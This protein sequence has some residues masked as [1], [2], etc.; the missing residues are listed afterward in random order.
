MR[1][2]AQRQAEQDAAG[3]P[4]VP[5][6][7]PLP[8]GAPA[9]PPPNVPAV[10][11][12]ADARGAVPA[13]PPA[14]VVPPG[15][16]APAGAV[17]PAA[18]DARTIAQAP[19][20]VNAQDRTIIMDFQDVELPVLVKFISE[21]TGRNFIVDEKVRGKVTIISPGKITVDEAYLVFQSVLQVKGF[22]TVQA[23]QVIK[24]VQTAE[25]KSSTL[26]TFLPP[27]QGQAGPRATDEYI[28]RL[29]PLKFVDANS[30]VSI[31]QPLVSPDGLLAAYTKTNTLI[32][33]DTAAQTER[34]A[35]IMSQLDV[36]GF[37]QKVEVVRLRYAFAGDL[38][39]LLQEVL[40]E[41]EDS[42]GGGAAVN[43]RPA[44]APD[45]RLRRGAGAAARQPA[46]AGGSATIS[47]GVT[48]ERSFRIIPDERIN[49]LIIMAGPMEMRRIQDLIARLDVPIPLGTGR[50]HVYYLKYAN[51][52]ELA[53][54]LSGLV[55]G[56]GGGGLS[57]GGLGGGGLGS[58][59]GGG[60][61]FGGTR[62]GFGS[63]G[64]GSSS[65]FG[66][67]GSSGGFGS[68]SFG[69]SGIGGGFGSSSSG[70]GGFGRGNLG[71]SANRRFGTGGSSFGGGGFGSRGGGGGG[72]GNLPGQSEFEGQVGISADP[73]T[74][75]LIVIASPQDYETIKEVIEKLDVRRRQVYVEAIIAEVSLDKTRELGIELQGAVDLAGKGAGFGRT[76]LGGDL[77][78]AATGISGIQSLSGLAL[79]A[80]SAQ[81][82]TIGGITIPAQQA[83]L[84]ALERSNDAEILS[85]PTL[86]TMDNT[87]AEIVAGQN[88]PFIASRS[89]NEVNLANTF[90]TIER[91]DVGIT[92]RLVPQISEGGSVR[93]D[94][95]QE[96]SAVISTDPQ[97]GPTTTVRSATTTIVVKDGH[98]GV[99]GGVLSDNA[100][101]SEV[102]IPYLSD[103]PVIGNLF[104]FSS[105][106]KAKTN[107]LV[108]LTPH[109]VRNEPEQT[110]LSLR[111]RERLIQ[112]PYED[113]G[114]RPPDWDELYNPSWEAG[115]EPE[116]GTERPSLDPPPAEATPSAE[117]PQ[118]G[119][120]TEPL[121]RGEAA[122]QAYAEAVPL[123]EAHPL[124]EPG[125]GDV[126]D[127]DASSAAATGP[128]E[129]VVLAT[130]W[131]EGTPP[132][133]LF[134]SN[135][136]VALRVA[137]GSTLS[138]M[139]QP[140]A[141]Y[142]F[143][144]EN[145]DAYF[146]CLEVFSSREEAFT[147]YPDG[148]RVSQY[149][150]SFLHWREPTDA[151]AQRPTN[152]SPAS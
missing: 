25:A 101:R 120:L 76:N 67:G 77:N 22:T 55:G 45:A 48:P 80:T 16:A 92:L 10:A 56:G 131:S 95:F 19:A 12:G 125:P 69:Q 123:V 89:T 35:K 70:Q 82:I 102:R 146:Q 72:Q 97:L 59:F 13:P 150:V 119:S 8:P 127:M 91:Q 145:F 32:I 106:G 28:T 109:I 144:S 84:R 108:F 98:T 66:G 65:R 21:I 142:R 46:A 96:V 121:A 152:W 140:G 137:S 110:R 113:R 18:T 4:G 6:G 71:S 61:G 58:S 90:A 64:S 57:G 9:P 81:S 111:E 52:L 74:N 17:A 105:V 5:Q 133:S 23:G 136:L 139:F 103:I 114:K 138:G 54:V 132:T 78:N 126:Y 14:G 73:A 1:A 37:E 36:E 30:M 39:A 11:P 130:V 147:I 40:Q 2:R 62:G 128:S 60:G 44:N 26:K 116:P 41:P 38:A 88:V 143:D 3:Q 85:A 86:M 124:P 100:T 118:Q 141:G 99:I 148:M 51:A 79:G 34:L 24:I 135:G 115:L 104:E 83:L 94:I 129:Y 87:E 43:T 7:A 15:G 47:G 107:L 53:D 42:G 31:I 49:S 149:P 20:P 63:R 50:I 75:A 122:A 93:L 29:M 151:A 68:S 33:I 27:G 117:P 112:K 134:G